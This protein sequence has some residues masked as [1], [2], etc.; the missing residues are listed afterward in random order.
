MV[1]CDDGTAGRRPAGRVVVTDVPVGSGASA[2]LRHDRGAALRAILD[3][4]A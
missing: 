2:M 3:G 4:P 1:G